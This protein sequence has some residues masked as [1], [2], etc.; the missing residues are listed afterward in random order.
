MFSSVFWCMKQTMGSWGGVTIY[1]YMGLSEN[2]VPLHPMVLL[3][4]IPTKWLFHWGYTPFS[5][6]PIYTHNK[7]PIKSYKSSEPPK[8]PRLQR[9]LIRGRDHQLLPRRAE[10]GAVAAASVAGE[11]AA[12]D[13]DGGRPWGNSWVFPIFWWFT[14]FFGDLPE[15]IEGL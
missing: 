14:L 15:D 10:H 7:I 11:G 6:I 12:G 9:S 4:I 8:F 13:G 1:I 3:I 5:D 2:S